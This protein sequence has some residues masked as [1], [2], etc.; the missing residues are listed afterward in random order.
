M[1]IVDW[2]REGYWFAKLAETP[3]VRVFGLDQT[4]PDELRTQAQ[5][6]LGRGEISN[7]VH[8]RMIMLGFGAAGGWQFHHHHS[9]MSYKRPQALVPGPGKL[10][11]RDFCGHLMACPD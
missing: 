2:E 8:D 3:L 6:L 4:F 7:E 1:N 9:H 11:P 10:D 5:M